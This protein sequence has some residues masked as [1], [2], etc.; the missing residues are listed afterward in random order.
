M[1]G[2]VE[3]ET[4]VL[5]KDLGVHLDPSLTFSTH[6]EQ[7]INKANRLLGFIQRSYTYLDGESLVKLYAALIHLH[8]E[9]A[10]A[11]WYPVY[12]KDSSL[13]ENVQ[14][15]ASK[16]VP[17]LRDEPDETRLQRL[18]EVPSLNSV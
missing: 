7:Q 17:G 15:R 13:L 6:C 18:H 2:P 5:E 1:T 3:L 10:N 8:L 16:L 4:T 11:V 14:R 9:Y 12:K